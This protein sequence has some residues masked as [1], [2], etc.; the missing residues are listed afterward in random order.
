MDL[1]GQLPPEGLR[2]VQ[3]LATRM[4]PSTLSEYVGQS[5]LLAE[6]LPVRRAIESGQ[7]VN[8]TPR[9]KLGVALYWH[10]W[11]LSSDVLDSLSQALRAAASHS[12][13]KA[14]A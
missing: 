8:V 14:A 6:G 3:P 4:R 7:L 11:N 12:L 1:F 10:C 2:E 9:H 5:H 13:H